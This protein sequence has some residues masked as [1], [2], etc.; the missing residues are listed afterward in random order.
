VLNDWNRVNVA[1]RHDS[2]IDFSALSW[3]DAIGAAE[4]DEESGRVRGG[5]CG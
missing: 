3:F 5:G 4:I 2:F 1:E